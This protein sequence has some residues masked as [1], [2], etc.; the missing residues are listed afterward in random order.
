[1]YLHGEGTHTPASASLCVVAIGCDARFVG[2]RTTVCRTPDGVFG[3]T[4]VGAAGSTSSG[5]I[6]S[7]SGVDTLIA[8]C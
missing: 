3:C 1:V 2:V 6:V 7:S 5:S 4:G 8:G